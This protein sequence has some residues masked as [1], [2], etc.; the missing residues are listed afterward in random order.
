LVGLYNAAGRLTWT[1]PDGT[2]ADQVAFEVD[3]ERLRD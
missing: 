1:L 2:K 3:V